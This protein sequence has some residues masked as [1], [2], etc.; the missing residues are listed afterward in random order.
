M[1]CRAHYVEG[2]NQ[3]GHFGYFLPPEE[4][5]KKVGGWPPS[6]GSLDNLERPLSK[7]EAP[8]QVRSS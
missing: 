5:Q 3:Q 6:A 8:D 2:N 4:E 7:K 1:F